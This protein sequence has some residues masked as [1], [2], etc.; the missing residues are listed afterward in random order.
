MFSNVMILRARILN[1]RIYIFRPFT[2]TDVYYAKLVVRFLTQS[3]LT[4]KWV[5][6]HMR[7]EL[8]PDAVVNFFLQW[9]DPVTNHS[10]EIV[11]DYVSIQ[12]ILLN[13][14]IVII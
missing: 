13:Y 1:N 7:R 11:R 9:V 8:P 12:I 6:C 5:Q 4:V 2:M 10:D 14:F 3:Y